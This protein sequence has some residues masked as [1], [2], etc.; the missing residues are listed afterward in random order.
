MYRL[1]Y[2]AFPEYGYEQEYAPRQRV[3]EAMLLAQ[4]RVPAGMQRQIIENDP[5]LFGPKQAPAQATPQGQ[6]FKG[7][8]GTTVMPPEEEAKLRA[9]LRTHRP[10]LPQSVYDDMV[11]QHK[12]AKGLR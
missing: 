2:L 4:A 9:A 1:S 12:A 6:P 7:Q 8:V 10:N 11:S 5:E 3:Q